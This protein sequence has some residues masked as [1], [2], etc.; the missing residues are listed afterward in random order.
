MTRKL[1]ETRGR[2]R[3]VQFRVLM[4]LCKMNIAPP[5]IPKY[6]LVV[7]PYSKTCHGRYYP[8]TDK[9]I[10]YLYEDPECTRER[11]YEDL[12]RT[13]LHEMA[14]HLQHH[15][16]YFIRVRGVMHNEQ[17]YRLLSE[18]ESDA[19]DAEIIY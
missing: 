11:N 10:V 12:F 3:S 6:T 15:D 8:E 7:K 13:V 14:H 5:R 16:P 18:L 19:R 2:R 17:F 1:S 4:D 9:L